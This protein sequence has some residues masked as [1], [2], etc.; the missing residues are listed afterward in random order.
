MYISYIST[1]TTLS[2]KYGATV[3]YYKYISA[4]SHNASV[5]IYKYSHFKLRKACV[6]QKLKKIFMQKYEHYFFLLI[7]K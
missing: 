5:T 6:A 2:R 1:K 4:P 7:L 3:L